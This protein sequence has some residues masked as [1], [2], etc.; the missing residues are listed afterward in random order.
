M[1]FETYLKETVLR[2]ENNKFDEIRARINVP[3]FRVSF[4][5]LLQRAIEGAAHLDISKKMMISGKVKAPEVWDA[6]YPSEGDF[7]RRFAERLYHEEDIRLLHG[8][9]GVMT[10]SGELLKALAEAIYEGKGL[11]IP[12]LREELGDI[13]W[14][15]SLICV[16][17]DTTPN[18]E[19]GRNSTKLRERYPQ[20]FTEEAHDNRNL[21]AERKVL[22]APIS[23]SSKND[24]YPDAKPKIVDSVYGYSPEYEGKTHVLAP[25]SKKY[26]GPRGC[27]TGCPVPKDEL[28]EATK[29]RVEVVVDG[30]KGSRMVTPAQ[31]AYVLYC[32]STLKDMPDTMEQ[33][34]IWLEEFDNLT[35]N[36]KIAWANVAAGKLVNAS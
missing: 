1:N 8:A 26:S 5:H 4:F 6:N 28:V 24:P 2:T 20:M 7:A 29:E 10:E 13:L 12:N 18:I 11:D 23:S 21:E 31:R 36:N 19:M 14:Y 9:I 16:S 15:L 30:G 32:R 25:Y 17:L 27:P 34:E 33:L 35:P 3:E 22:E